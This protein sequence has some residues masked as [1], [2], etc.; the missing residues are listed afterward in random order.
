MIITTTD[1]IGEFNGQADNL[2][3]TVAARIIDQVEAWAEEYLGRHLESK[4]RTVY[5]DVVGAQREFQLKGYPVS[6]IDVRVD[7]DRAWPATT[8]L[9]TGDV[10][11]DPDTGLMIVEHRVLEGRRVMKVTYTGGMAANQADFATKF[12]AIAIAADEQ[13][14][15]LLQRAHDLGTKSLGYQGQSIAFEPSVDLLPVF[16]RSLDPFQ[17]PAAEAETDEGEWS[18]LDVVHG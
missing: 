6:A 5:L 7:T 10:W 15:H 12:P 3:E 1:R 16:K 18:T 8:K 17:S 2:D 11:V 13:V 14:H 9:A 4:S